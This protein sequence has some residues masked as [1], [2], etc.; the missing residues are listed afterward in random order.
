M[1]S[2]NDITQRLAEMLTAS[3]EDTSLWS[4]EDRDA[5]G[6]TQHSNRTVTSATGIS[7]TREEAADDPVA[8][9]GRGPTGRLRNF[10]AMSDAKLIET[11][12][13]VAYENNDSEALTGI[14]A[15]AA[16]RGLTL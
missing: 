16:S 8:Y 10:R 7:P 3:G 1:P 2:D 13:Q 4:A 5:E 9:F 14:R 15:E 11:Y 6:V 12:R